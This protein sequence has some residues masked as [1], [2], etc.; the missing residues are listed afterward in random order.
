MTAAV[1]PTRCPSPSLS[2]P[3]FFPLLSPPTGRNQTND[4]RAG[5]PP[6]SIQTPGSRFQLFTGA[7]LLVASSLC[8][9]SAIG[10][11][12]PDYNIVG[13]CGKSA[14]VGG[15][16]VCEVLGRGWGWV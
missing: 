13:E 16:E 6:V 7:L 14:V 11:Q 8:S 10:W 15:G 9:I 4:A 5:F 2:L 3:L 12:G 1:P